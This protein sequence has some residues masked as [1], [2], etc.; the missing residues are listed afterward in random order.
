ME[1]VHVVRSHIA[2]GLSNSRR[3][4]KHQAIGPRA[5]PAPAPHATRSSRF[6][7]G[8]HLHTAGRACVRDDASR[9]LDRWLSHP[10]QQKSPPL[11][12]FLLPCCARYLHLRAAMT[13]GIRACSR[14][15][16]IM[17]ILQA[18]FPFARPGRS[19]RGER[20]RR[21]V[22]PCACMQFWV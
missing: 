7:S 19:R 22:W 3:T 11:P 8:R 21:I 18:G 4:R 12:S 1:G 2:A 20:G 5:A 10:M 15:H 13:R 16:L 6:H 9:G 14:L 17:S